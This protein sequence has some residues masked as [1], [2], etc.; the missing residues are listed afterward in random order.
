MLEMF[1]AL[2]KLGLLCFASVMSIM[3]LFGR[4]K[5]ERPNTASRH[6]LCITLLSFGRYIHRRYGGTN[7]TYLSVIPA[8]VQAKIT[9][10]CV[11]TLW[12]PCQFISVAQEPR[13]R[14]LEYCNTFYYCTIS[15]FV[16]FI[17]IMWCLTLI[18]Y[19]KNINEKY[20]NTKLVP[21]EHLVAF[22]VFWACRSDDRL[23]IMCP[24]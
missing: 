16:R 14:M 19:T 20:F 22:P 10:I 9:Y 2:T 4:E 1:I 8:N 6:D 3:S 5:Y 21:V 15:L 24:Y 17:F 12:K 23:I 18:Y 13:S 7:I 11:C